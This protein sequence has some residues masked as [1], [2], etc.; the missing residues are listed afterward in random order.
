MLGNS[1]A[2]DRAKSE[3]PHG[4]NDDHINSGQLSRRV[5][6]DHNIRPDRSRAGI[7]STAALTAS[8]TLRVDGLF[9]GPRALSVRLT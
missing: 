7:A 6:I 1:S 3:T 2:I 5:R 9:H 8:E 4:A